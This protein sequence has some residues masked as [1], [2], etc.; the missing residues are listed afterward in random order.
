LINHPE[1]VIADL[2]K[3][4]FLFLGNFFFSIYEKVDS[5]GF[6]LPIMLLPQLIILVFFVYLLVIFYLSYFTSLTKEEASA[7]TDYLLMSASIESEKEIGSFDDIIL[8][9]V[10]LLYVFG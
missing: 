1:L 6:L 2:E 5:E 8:V 10:V 9:M 3:S 7:D 4:N